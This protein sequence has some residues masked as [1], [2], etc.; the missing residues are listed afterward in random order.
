MLKQAE[1]DRDVRAAIRE[2][3]LELNQNTHY[4]LINGQP[5]K[6]TVVPRHDVYNPQEIKEA[7]IDLAGRPTRANSN[8]QFVF[9]N[10][11]IKVMQSHQFVARKSIG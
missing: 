7:T 4:D 8:M 10:S 2:R 1:Q 3:T 11:P 6:V 9:F 5:R